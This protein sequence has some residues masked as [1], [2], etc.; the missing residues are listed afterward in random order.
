M[1]TVQ[2]SV[3]AIVVSV[4]LIATQLAAT[5]YESRMSTLLLRTREF[6]YLF[7]LFIGSIFLDIGIYLSLGQLQ[8]PAV[9]GFLYASL[10]LFM[11]TL[12]SVYWFAKEM[13]T[14]ATPEELVG[15]FTEMVSADEYIRDAESLAAK[16]ESNSHTLQP[17]FRFTM[18][19]L[20]QNEYSVA[21]SGGDHYVTYCEKILGE[22][23]D[24][25]LLEQESFG[26]KEELFGPVLKDHLHKITLHAAEKDESQIRTK[27]IAGQVALAE[28]AVGMD[29]YSRIP[30]QAV[31]GIENTIRESPNSRRG[32]PALNNCWNAIGDLTI[33]AADSEHSTFMLTIRTTIDS[34][35]GETIR[36][37]EGPGWLSGSSRKLFES[38]CEAHETI[39]SEV[40]EEHRLADFGPTDLHKDGRDTPIAP[41]EQ[42]RYCRQALFEVT[43]VF[44]EDRI[45][46][47][48]WLPAAGNYKREWKKL[49]ITTAESGATEMAIDLCE[50]L[51]QMAYIEND[52]E[53]PVADRFS[54]QGVTPTNPNEVTQWAR[55]LSEIAAE[56]DEA[57]VAQAFSNILSHEQIEDNPGLFIL[58]NSDDPAYE[59]AYR[60]DLNIDGYS[61]LNTRENYPEAI[62][63]LR[64]AVQPEEERETASE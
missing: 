36:N 16:P 24:R 41:I 18:T 8:H 63:A 40:G 58:S 45:D 6:R 12:G 49:I 14:Q 42:L 61:H 19:A 44:L 13:V 48:R 20:S 5:N 53:I 22:V 33:L 29:S 37:V 62:M 50:V 7:A 31:S 47:G 60:F 17:L 15:R 46:R 28:Q 1:I 32:H 4:T 35:L 9:S 55:E 51:I 25:G 64:E 30:R 21:M 57:V 23:G 56:T 10:L 27:A 59:D 3:L 2:G 43:S 11:L 34:W 39:L 54:P 52:A 26:A 38:L